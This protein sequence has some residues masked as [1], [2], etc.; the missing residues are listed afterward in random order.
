M[1]SGY[2]SLLVKFL[3]VLLLVRVA[4]GQFWLEDSQRHLASWMHEISNSIEA[5]QLVKLREQLAPISA[6]WRDYQQAYFYEVSQSVSG[7]QQFYRMYCVNGDKNPYIFANN[8]T[9]TCQAIT[10]SELLDQST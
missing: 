2:F 4:V 3:A 7:V 8:L 5:H 9:K 10:N 6:G 1:F